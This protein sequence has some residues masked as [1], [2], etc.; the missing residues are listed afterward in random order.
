M[1]QLSELFKFKWKSGYKQLQIITISLQCKTALEKR[2]IRI[3]PYGQ[4]VVTYVTNA[5]VDLQQL[6]GIG[7][8]L[9]KRLQEAV[10][11]FLRG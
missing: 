11:F 1:L 10:E 6:K 9:V 3:A 2:I 5:K 4:G 8:A 7:S